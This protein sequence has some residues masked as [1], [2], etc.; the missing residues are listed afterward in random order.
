MRVNES[1]WGLVKI[2]LKVDDLGDG[3]FSKLMEHFSRTP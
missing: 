1:T 2:A 3:L